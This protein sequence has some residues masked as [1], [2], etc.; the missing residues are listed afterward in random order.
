[1]H[2]SAIGGLSTANESICSDVAISS[3]DGSV[4]L[5]EEPDGS[6]PLS[7]PLAALDWSLA[8]DAAVS[9]LSED[10]EPHAVRSSPAINT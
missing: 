7:I 9:S 5:S 4:E 1:M 6:D 2:T 10:A 8:G 3:V